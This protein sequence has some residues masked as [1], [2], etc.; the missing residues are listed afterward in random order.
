MDFVAISAQNILTIFET[1]TDDGTCDDKPFLISKGMYTK[2]IP[3][4]VSYNLMVD[5]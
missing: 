4:L 1:Y 5:K 2:L 3:A